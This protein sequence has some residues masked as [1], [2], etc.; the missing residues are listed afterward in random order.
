MYLVMKNNFNKAAFGSP[1]A[2]LLLSFKS[3]VLNQFLS[4]DSSVQEFPVLRYGSDFP[5]MLQHEHSEQGKEK[6]GAKCFLLFLP[7]LKSFVQ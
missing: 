3:I 4:V 1:S 2:A 6:A 7:L 5:G